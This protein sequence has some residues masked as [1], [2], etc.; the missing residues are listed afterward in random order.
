MNALK[1]KRVFSDEHKRKLSESHKGQTSSRKGKT[2]VDK[3]E[4]K[5]KRSEYEKKWKSENRE[6]LRK[7]DRAWKS[8]NREKVNE[9]SKKAYHR[10]KER[11]LDRVRFRKYGITGEEFRQR[12]AQQHYKCSVCGGDGSDKNLSVDHS[13][14]TGK[15]RGLI[16]NSC[17]MALGNVKDSIEIL[18]NLIT[19]LEYYGKS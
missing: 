10:R 12:L 2:F 15:I 4:S 13:H 19:Y 7:L 11:A 18:K 1:K 17:N 5:K 14:E 16:C 9:S 8:K 6:R 3:E